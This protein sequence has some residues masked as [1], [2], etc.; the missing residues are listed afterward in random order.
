M[1]RVYQSAYINLVKN[2][3]AVLAY[4]A[5]GQ[6]ERRQYWNPQTG[7]TEVGGPKNEHSMPGH[8]LLLMGEDLTHYRIWDGIRALDYLLTRPEVDPERAGC[9]GQSGGGTLTLFI[10]ALDPRVK[11]AVVSEGGTANRWPLEIR[12]GARVGPADVEQNL[13]PAAIYGIDLPDLHMAIAPRGR[14]SR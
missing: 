14:Y 6:G 3:I 1:Y 11:C 12:P 13:F 9:A 5:I 8:L 4:D 7:E 2:G 10:S